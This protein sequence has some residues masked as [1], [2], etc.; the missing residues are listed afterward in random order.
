MASYGRIG[1][2][3]AAVGCLLVAVV[4]PGLAWDQGSEWQQDRGTDGYEAST[5]YVEPAPDEPAKS[6]D[7]HEEQA[8]PPEEQP[9]RDEPVV[10]EWTPRFLPLPEP[11]LTTNSHKCEGKLGL[12]V[13]GAQGANATAEAL[14]NGMVVAYCKA[15]AT[16][17]QP[18][19]SFFGKC[20]VAFHLDRATK[21][22]CRIASVTPNADKALI[23]SC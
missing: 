21:D 4:P 5:A 6:A 12:E 13:T 14:C 8:S 9:V 23:T 18:S 1:K 19:G 7:S 16:T 15:H 17:A 22:G 11:A 3:I 2:G 20:E 10:F